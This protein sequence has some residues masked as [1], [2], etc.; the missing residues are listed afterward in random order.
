VIT[1]KEYYSN[2]FIE[3]FG[4]PLSPYDGIGDETIQAKLN[5]IDYSVPIALTDYYAIAGNHKINKEYNILRSL[6]ELEWFGDTL[7]FMEENQSVAYWGIKREDCNLPDPIVWQGQNINPLEFELEDDEP[8]EWYAEPYKIS[9][10]LMA[11]WKFT[12]TGEQEQPES[13][14][15]A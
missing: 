4:S 2:R 11:M 5:R 9:R 14:A 3:I 15:D 13:S 12:L 8:M 1:F 7:I 6:N 10:F